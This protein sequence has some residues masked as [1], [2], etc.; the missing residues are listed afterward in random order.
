MPQKVVPSKGE[1]QPVEPS[2][3]E[4]IEAL[5]ESRDC[6][7]I[8]MDMVEE[9]LD[10]THDS[11]RKKHI[12]E[13]TIT[14]T[15]TGIIEDIT[16]MLAWHFN[17]CDPGEPSAASSATWRPDR[18]A[19][20]AEIDSWSRGAVPARKSKAFAPLP[21]GSALAVAVGGL[22]ESRSTSVPPRSPP[23]SATRAP[24]RP[25]TSTSN[26]RTED[27]SPPVQSS[28][29]IAKPAVPPVKKKKEPPLV[30]DSERRAA[31]LR[32]EQQEEH[33]R[34]ERMKA[35]LKGK[36]YIYDN[37]GG[38]IPL[39][40]YA[41]DKLPAYQQ[42]P[43]IAVSEAAKPA[44]KGTSAVSKSTRKGGNK[45]K[46]DFTKPPGF[47][48]LDSMQP[49]LID[50][51]V[52]REGV[53]LIEGDAVKGGE[54]LPS[55]P[56]RMS[57]KEFELK[58]MGGGADTGMAAS[59]SV[60][61]AASFHADESL[62][63]P[64]TATEPF[65]PSIGGRMAV[66]EPSAQDPAMLPVYKPTS[67]TS[68]GRGTEPRNNITRERGGTAVKERLPPP[69]LPATV[70]FGLELPYASLHTDALASLSSTKKLAF[71]SPRS[72]PPA[73]VKTANSTLLKQVTSHQHS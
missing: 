58:V 31:Q 4:L 43:R 65:S 15:A 34:M 73:S 39:E 47:K 56:E 16:V 3:D 12:R 37:K 50:S 59:R 46:V 27:A 63:Q 54:P 71:T 19:R 72:I 53:K 67:H 14:H 61:D 60:T 57:R 33:E 40:P 8:V 20:P 18:E 30:T 41:P 10:L 5:N 13:A 7:I 17:D 51:M 38:L 6:E 52:V 9:L 66:E 11:L 42:A 1:V 48:E 36:D 29:F 24:S 49:P 2:P 28:L 44:T 26:V 68:L 55:V 25:P 32:A 35:E 70:G 62:M 69:M 21:A 23:R 64:S 22:G 45:L